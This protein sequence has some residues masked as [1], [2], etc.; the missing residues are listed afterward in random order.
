MTRNQYLFQKHDVD[1]QSFVMVKV[2]LQN[3]VQQSTWVPTRALAEGRFLRL[4]IQNG[5]KIRVIESNCSQY[6]LLGGEGSPSSFLRKSWVMNNSSSK[7]FMEVKSCNYILVFR[8]QTFKG[9][10][11]QS[12]FLRKSYVL[13]NFHTTDSRRPKVTTALSVLGTAL[14]RTL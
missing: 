14:S 10:G 2:G 7:R 4:T 12:T 3:G 9:Q 13:N 5:E 8:V 11:S 1:F 6:Q